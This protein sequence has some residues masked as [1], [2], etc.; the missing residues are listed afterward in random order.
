[1]EQVAV[2]IVNQVLSIIL[3]LIIA[4]L[5]LQFAQITKFTILSRENVKKLRLLARMALSLTKL[6]NNV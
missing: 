1:M 5:R 2:S 4:S 3:K 6:A